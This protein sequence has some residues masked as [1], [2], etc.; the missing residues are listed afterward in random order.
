ML[1][2]ALLLVRISG[3]IYGLVSSDELNKAQAP[4]TRLKALLASFSNRLPLIYR[5]GL[6]STDSP[7]PWPVPF[8]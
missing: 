6:D 3:I 2:E 8:P 1:Q 4:W 7:H 5:Q